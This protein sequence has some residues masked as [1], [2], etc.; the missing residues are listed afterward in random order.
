MKQRLNLT[1]EADLIRL[2]RQVAHERDTSVSALVEEYLRNLPSRAP[3]S[4][5]AFVV[6]WAGRLSLAPPDGEPRREY[7][8]RKFALEQSPAV[9]REASPSDVESAAEQKEPGCES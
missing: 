3:G 6:K 7:L 1:V 2:A 5:A 9:L 8:W 4:G